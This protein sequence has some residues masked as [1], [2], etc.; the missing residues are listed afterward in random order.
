MSKKMGSILVLALAFSALLLLP[1]SASAATLKT[2]NRVTTSTAFYAF[3]G[4]ITKGAQKGTPLTGGL[5]L[6][7]AN[8]GTFTGAYHRPDTSSL[9]VKGLTKSDGSIAISFLK[10][11]ADY[12]KGQGTANASHEYTGV[13]QMFNAKK[14]VST[15]IWSAIPADPKAMTALAFEGTVKQGQDKGSPMAGAIVLNNKTMTGS[16]LEANG[17]V[18]AA[19]AKLLN[20]GKKIQVH[21]GNNIVSNGKAVTTPLKGYQ[22]SFTGPLTGDMGIWEAFFFSF[23]K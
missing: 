12:V 23:Q 17:N 6:L 9:S 3:T 21:I 14:E 22:G 20:G 16:L 1:L 8:S 4:L 5:S 2:P 15:G 10:N 11:K 13:F 18:S 19:K 7:L